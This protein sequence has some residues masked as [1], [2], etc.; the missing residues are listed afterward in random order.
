MAA[1][2]SEIS[3]TGDSAQEFIEV[4]V[5]AGTD[6][7]SYSVVH[8]LID[9]NGDGVVWQT[10]ALGTV[11]STTS[12]QDVYTIDD[13]DPDVPV[14]TGSGNEMGNIYPDD[15]FALVDDTGTVVQFVSFYG[16]TMTPI[17]GP[18]AGMTSTMIGT[19]PGGQSLQSDDG[20]S[21][22]YDQPSPNRNSIPCFATGTLI[23]TEDGYRPV[24][25]LRIGDK[26]ETVDRGPQPI[27]WIRRYQ[28]DLTHAKPDQKP[29][30]IKAGALGPNCPSRSLVVSPQHRI[31]IGT[32]LQ[33]PWA[34]HPPALAPAKALTRIRGI[35]P[36][37]GVQKLDYIHFA[38]D[39]HETIWAEGAQVESLFLGCAVIA[40][41]SRMQR[42]GLDA[43][44]AIHQSEKSQSL[45]ILTVS[46]ARHLQRHCE[47]A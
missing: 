29:I 15:A 31:V 39:H 16:N 6:T 26:V 33:T 47:I 9:G 17:N 43:I 27:R 30:Q 1:Y 37:R 20:G 34:S 12:G 42:C 3:I 19:P 21:T 5:T 22:Y 10:Y 2:F 14:T 8:Y 36:K 44:S 35:S 32:D 13:S 41:L 28:A 25:D 4:A 18:A 38:L 46:Q 23:L 40:G 7:S 24:E 11:E 45:R